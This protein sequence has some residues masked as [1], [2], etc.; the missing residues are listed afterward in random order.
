MTASLPY[1]LYRTDQVRDGE[2]KIAA[3]LGV[4]MYTLMD[5]A[6][7][8]AFQTLQERWPEAKTI[9]IACG[10]GN[11]GG[12]GYVVAKLAIEAGFNVQVWAAVDPS[13]LQGDAELAFKAFV[14]AGGKAERGSFPD[15]A[16]DLLVDA[17]L[18]TGL[19]RP[20]SP[21]YA[22]AIT[23][24]NQCPCP[25]LS[26]DVPSGLDANKGVVLGKA[27]RATATITFVALKQGMFTGV[28]RDYCG[29][30]VF[31]G[32]GI[33]AAFEANIAPSA[34]LLLA[35][36]VQ[37]LEPQRKRSAHKGQLG[38]LICIGGQK[39]MGGAIILCGQAALR[40][41]A[42]LVSLLTAEVNMPAILARQPELMTMFWR[43]RQGG[44]IL[45][46]TLSWGD[47]I[48]IGPGLGLSSWSRHLFDGALAMNVPMVLDADA[49]NLL[50]QYPCRY[51]NWVLTP[52]PGEAARLLSKA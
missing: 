29:D 42:G 3:D 24:I 39:G 16:C 36:N 11:N 46:H 41:G 8:A 50:A 19:N 35:D 15:I 1:S 44:E 38:R 17:L 22:E 51:G 48:A 12:D 49:L 33:F 52:H 32:L 37:H 4:E 10:G 43:E 47:V 26:I 25:V 31:D 30:I 2:R 6:G 14:A 18:G 5:R 23:A 21:D 34:T 28:A 20:V 7:Q 45:E 27:V 40:T 13:L 9:L